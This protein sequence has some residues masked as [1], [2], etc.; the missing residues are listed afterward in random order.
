MLTQKISKTINSDEEKYSIYFGILQA[1]AGFKITDQE[2]LILSK[3]MKEGEL[4]KNVKDELKMIASKARIDNVISKFRK[5]KILVGNKP[6][7]KFPKLN[8]KDMSFNITLK[9]AAGN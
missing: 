7:S 4:T 3:I 8:G 5:T 1:I 2:K 9:N 6:N